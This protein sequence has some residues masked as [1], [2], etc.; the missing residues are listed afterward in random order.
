M[1]DSGQV[2]LEYMMVA[3]FLTAALVVVFGAAFGLFSDQKFAQ[4][5][6]EARTGASDLADMVNF[7]CTA[8][9]NTTGRTAVYLPPLMDFDQ[10]SISNRTIQF[11]LKS[12]ETNT[13]ATA[14]TE[15]NVTGTLPSRA[16]TYVFRGVSQG[17]SGGSVALNFTT[18][19]ANLRPATG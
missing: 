9:R 14:T 11:A 10:S 13:V 17:G 7:L 8:P 19:I 15:C 12:R 1:D 3:I 6:A 18:N 5:L 2:S 4:Q 16:G